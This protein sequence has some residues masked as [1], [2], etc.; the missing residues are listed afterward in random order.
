MIANV[1][2]LSGPD[3]VVKALD[4]HPYARFSAAMATG[5][6][7]LDCPEGAVLWWG[8]TAF[9]RL[10]EAG[11]QASPGPVGWI[12]VRR[13]PGVEPDDVA[14]QRVYASLGYADS[15]PLAVVRQ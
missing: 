12:N 13:T 7:G 8:E 11:R 3:K 15:L 9:G 1:I 5:V 2:S 6:A 10:I 14:A 4:A